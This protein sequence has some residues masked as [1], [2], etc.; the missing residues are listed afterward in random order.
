MTVNSVASKN[1]IAVRTS[2]SGVGE[3]IRRSE[4][5]HSSVISSRSR[6]RTS[7]SSNGVN[8]VSSSR[9]SRIAHASERDERRPAARLRRVG[10]QDRGDR[11]TTDQRI[12]LRLRPSQPT[13]PGDRVRHRVLQ[14][15]VARRTLAP[16]QGA[17]AAARFGQVDEPEV[18]REGADHG[19]RR[20]QVERPQL[21]VEPRPF[22]RVIVAAKGDRASPDPLDQGEE[23]RS[24]LFGDDLAEQ[25]PAGGPPP[26]TGREHPPSRS[27]AA[28]RRP[29]PRCAMTRVELTRATDPLRSAPEPPPDRNLP[30]R[31]LSVGLYRD[32]RDECPNRVRQRASRPIPRVRVAAGERRRPTR[33][34]P[35]PARGRPPRHHGADLG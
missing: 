2:S 30:D 33:T 25:C 35:L 5:R 15:A 32:T 6:R 23:F 3:T 29:R 26:P 13:Q 28:P 34:A 14:H 12:Q 9:A 1:A 31:N 17:D 22:Q 7:R 27:R 8:R 16:A 21:L 18:E 19:L 20:A 10:R 4:V 24:C 11:Q